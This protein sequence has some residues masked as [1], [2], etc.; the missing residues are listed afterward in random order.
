VEKLERFWRSLPPEQRETVSH[1]VPM[2]LV[3]L[4]E[5]FV[6]ACAT[7][8]VDSSV[9]YAS[10]AERLLKQIKFDYGLVISLVGRQFTV[11]DLVAHVISTNNLDQ[12]LA[13]F[14]ALEK[15]F[16]PK[17]RAVHPRWVE[18]QASWPLDPIIV[19]YDTLAATLALMFEA[20]HIV[21]HELPTAAPYK[22]SDLDGFF[23]ATRQMIEAFEWLTIELTL[24]VVPL[25]QTEITLAGVRRVDDLEH[26]MAKLLT[27]LNE[28]SDVKPDLL[29][30]CQEKWHQYARAQ[31]ALRASLVE[32][33]SMYPSV[34]NS[35]LAEL[36]EE[37]IARLQSWLSREDGEV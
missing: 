4:I 28:R 18:E 23:I 5:V 37:R 11:G 10:A 35:E 6:R 21:T 22:P 26:E 2:R 30:E 31:S 17:L 8:L 12:I 15:D 19:N 27:L 13:T 36:Q 16:L 29:R 9:I 32:G 24:G 14:T 34:F 1:Y 3:T 7:R 25:T 20:R 33:G